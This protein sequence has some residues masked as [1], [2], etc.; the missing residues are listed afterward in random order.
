MA[1]STPAFKYELLFS[2]EKGISGEGGDSILSLLHFCEILPG[3]DCNSKSIVVHFLFEES[4][5][6]ALLLRLLVFELFNR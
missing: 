4:I 6:T 3:T 5:Q 1:N 2:S